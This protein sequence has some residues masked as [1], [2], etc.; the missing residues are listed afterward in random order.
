[1]VY[2]QIDRQTDGWTPDQKWLEKPTWA[3][4]SGELERTKRK[5]IKKKINKQT[6]KTKTEK[7]KKTNKK[8]KNPQNKTKQMNN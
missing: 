8:Q 4:S 1:M 2:D 3:F 5:K 6:N 7:T